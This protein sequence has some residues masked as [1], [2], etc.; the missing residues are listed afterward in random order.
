MAYLVIVQTQDKFPKF[1]YWM[2]NTTHAYSTIKDMVEVGKE[3]KFSAPKVKST[4][5]E[6]FMKIATQNLLTLRVT[7]PGLRTPKVMLEVSQVAFDLATNGVF[8]KDLIGL[9]LIKRY[10]ELLNEKALLE[11]GGRRPTP[12]RSAETADTSSQIEG[13]LKRTSSEEDET[14]SKAGKFDDTVETIEDTR[15]YM[16]NKS[17]PLVIGF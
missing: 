15:Y 13:T 8:S 1:V 17:V 2:K 7:N 4:S 14:V 12:S 3:Y 10:E 11:L 6:S 16:G 5:Y 9:E